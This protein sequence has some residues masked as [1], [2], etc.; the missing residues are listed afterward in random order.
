MFGLTKRD[1]QTI[2]VRDSDAVTAALGK[3][4][5][6]A[7]PEERPGLERALEIAGGVCSSSEAE[8]QARWVRAHLDAAAVTG[9]ADSVTA[10]KALREAA[11]GMSL[12]AAVELARTT[13]AVEDAR[14]A[15]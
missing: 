5:A 2:F 7:P 13:R 14:G 4:L 8:T 9:P 1:A 12:L 15:A 3:A 6:E 10:I 11:P